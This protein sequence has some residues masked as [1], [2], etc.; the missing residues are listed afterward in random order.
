MPTIDTFPDQTR[1]YVRVEVNWADVPSAQYVGVDR[2][3]PPNG[4]FTPQ[5]P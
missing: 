2:G 3:A 5:G 4:E 1:A